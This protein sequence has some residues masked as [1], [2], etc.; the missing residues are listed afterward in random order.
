MLPWVNLMIDVSFEA[1]HVLADYHR[2]QDMYR[3]GLHT[4]D[5]LRE[6]TDLHTIF[7]I[8][9]LFTYTYI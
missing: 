9:N 6:V 4:E 2:Y 8:Y 5:E 1:I 7:I 3:Q